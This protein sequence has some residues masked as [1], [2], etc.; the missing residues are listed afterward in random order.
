MLHDDATDKWIEQFRNADEIVLREIE[1]NLID[2]RIDW[3]KQN[4]EEVEKLHG[5]I[6]E[7]AYQLLLLK[8][9]IDTSDA[10]V[11]EKTGRCIVFHSVNYCPSLQAC[12]ELGLDTRV[13]CKAVFE[14]PADTLVKQLHPNLQFGRNYACIRPYSTYCEEKIFWSD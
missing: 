13:I 5:D 4:Y 6:L 7:K 3:F 11:V 8:I 1:Q 9:G 10:P 12:V 14:K 2:R